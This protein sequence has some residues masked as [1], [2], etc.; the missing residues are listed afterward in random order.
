MCF[1]P[2]LIR[3]E[4][5]QF[6][7]KKA[8]FQSAFAALC[9]GWRVLQDHVLLSPSGRF[10]VLLGASGEHLFRTPGFQE[11]RVLLNAS[12]CN[13][14]HREKLRKE[15]LLLSASGYFWGALFR[16]KPASETPF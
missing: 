3:A 12:G 5:R 13:V 8:Y 6:A 7:S 11:L 2:W 10:W 4:E 15:G 16:S 1:S 14:L 9:L